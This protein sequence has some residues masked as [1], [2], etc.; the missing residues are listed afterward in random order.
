MSS[1]FHSL[2]IV[3]ISGELDYGDVVSVG[4]DLELDVILVG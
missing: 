2:T 4:P 1:V 3:R